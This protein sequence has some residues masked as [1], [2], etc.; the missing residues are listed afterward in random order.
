[1]KLYIGQ[2][3][4]LP[5]LESVRLGKTR[6][7]AAA[8]LT[9][10]VLTAPADT[11]FLKLSVAVGDP[12]RL[13]D[14]GGK[15]IFLGSV[16]EIDRTPDA[17]TL[18]AYDR[19]IYLTRNELYGVYTGTGKTIAGK[20]AGELGIPLGTVEDDGLRRTIVTGAGQSAFSI[21][22]KAVGE[23]REI[24]VKD[25]ALTVTKGGG[26]AVLLPPERVLEVTSR[27]SIRSM[28]NRAVV[29]GRNGNRLAS[30]EN[31]GEIAAYGR[32][33][34]VLG[35]DG[36]PAEQAK[37]ALQGRVLSARVTLLGNLAYRC[38]GTVK[39][40]RPQWGLEG[41]YTVTAH[42][43]RWEKGLF[44]TSLSLEGIHT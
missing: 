24:A 9:A 36:D 16:H 33:Q 21:L 27:A 5:A 11:Y 4:V 34:Q 20:I 30:A 40:D 7:E 42:E 8:T 22:R 35:K 10:T 38:G 26:N 2:Q 17:V 13:L 18:T 28:V 1:M 29:V 12:V 31:A 25:G 15:E 44:T 39:A 6:S 14:D 32:F 41:L 43:H 23:G 3:M 37:A 19:G